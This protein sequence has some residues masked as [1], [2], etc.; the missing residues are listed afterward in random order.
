M[1]FDGLKTVR[2]RLEE[3]EAEKAKVDE[4]GSG[5]SKVKN[6]MFADLDKEYNDIMNL[7][8]SETD[9]DKSIVELK[10]LSKTANRNVYALQ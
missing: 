10:V 9:L 1:S 6:R 8:N 2:T 5:N 4:W 3:I 7:V